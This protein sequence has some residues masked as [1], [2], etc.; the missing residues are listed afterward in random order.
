MD[1]DMVF[2]KFINDFMSLDSDHAKSTIKGCK[3]FD[4]SVKM[5]G[6]GMVGDIHNIDGSI[7]MES[8]GQVSYGIVLLRFPKGYF[9]TSY[10]IRKNFDFYAK[11]AQKGS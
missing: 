10:K 4:E 3:T 9:D 5:W 8:S 6:F 11:L 2:W 7:V 1:Y